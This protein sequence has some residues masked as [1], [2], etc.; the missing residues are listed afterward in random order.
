MVEAMDESIG[1]I[2]GALARQGLDENTLVWFLSD[3]G[4]VIVDYHALGP[5]ATSNAPL[6]GEKG[7]LYEGGIRIPSVVRWPGRIAPGATS[8]FRAIT[9]DLCPTLVELAG[10]PPVETSGVSLAGLLQGGPEPRERDLFWHYPFYHHSTPASAIRSGQW[11][12]IEFFETGQCELYDLAADPGERNNL[13]ARMPDRVRDLLG[14]LREWRKKTG[15]AMP[16]PNPDYDPS[17]A[18]LWGKRPSKPWMPPPP[19][20]VDMQRECSVFYDLFPSDRCGPK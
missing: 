2:L 18:Y 9:N 16:T 10:L 1:L 20:I 13:A 15:A 7:A 5:I 14:R 6:R 3:N 4:G 12:L 8:G 11:K 19:G 17:R